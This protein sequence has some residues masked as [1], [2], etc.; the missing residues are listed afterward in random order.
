M[1]DEVQ[2]VCAQASSLETTK[3]VHVFLPAHTHKMPCAG[4]LCFLHCTHCPLLVLPGKLSR[5]ASRR[6]W[7]VLGK[8]A[9][10]V[11]LAV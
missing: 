1:Q 7:R 4:Q 8:H 3:H 11:L 2:L 6:A 9:H 5:S 10:L